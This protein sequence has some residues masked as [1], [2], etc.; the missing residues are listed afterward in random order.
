METEQKLKY[1]PIF[2]LKNNAAVCYLNSVLQSFLTTKYLLNPFE[3]YNEKQYTTSLIKLI[4]NIRS[5]K[6]FLIT[7][8]EEQLQ[9]LINRKHF[10]II[11]PKKFIRK[12][13][14][15]D[16]NELSEY[17]QQDA[18][19]FLTFLID[20]VY[21]ETKFTK[22]CYNKFRSYTLC[23]D[24]KHVNKSA[25][26]EPILFL[27]LQDS[28]VKSLSKIVKPSRPK[29]YKCEN[30]DKKNTTQ[31]QIFPKKIAKLFIVTLLRFDNYGRK[32]DDS[33]KVPLN[34]PINKIM[35]M[36]SHPEE[37]SEEEK[38]KIYKLK[39]AIFHHGTYNR[40]HYTCISKRA[41][42]EWYHFNDEHVEHIEINN[43]SIQNYLS[44]AYILIYSDE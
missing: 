3:E 42:N 44:K 40:G 34:L 41:N 11:D 26:K 10:A 32:I 39:S 13:I 38:N 4:D 18:H 21:E 33:I 25:E 14:R 2:G 35:Y 43:P 36:N 19:V 5:H 27:S 28:L 6:H 24:C 12:F 15:T 22:F 30:C 1:L 7:Q 37:I 23:T 17:A 8:N 29:D 31:K 9:N 20:K 16:E